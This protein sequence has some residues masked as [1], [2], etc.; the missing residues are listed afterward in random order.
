MSAPTLCLFVTGSLT[1]G[2]AG[3]GGGGAAQLLA[4]T[5]GMEEQPTADDLRDFERDVDQNVLMAHL[6]V[7]PQDRLAERVPDNASDAEVEERGEALER[8]A[9]DM[10]ARQRITEGYLN[11]AGPECAP[12][13]PLPCPSACGRR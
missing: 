5:M 4:G 8:I 3:V 6:Q 2:H 7:N 1:S 9:I 10:A 13:H 12:P 11:Y